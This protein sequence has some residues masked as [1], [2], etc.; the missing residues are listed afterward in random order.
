MAKLKETESHKVLAGDLNRDVLV[1]TP[2]GDSIGFRQGDVQVE[3]NTLLKL[4]EDPRVAHLAFD[5]GRS[6]YFGSII[7]GV[8]NSL[9]LKIRERG[10]RVALCD[11]SEDMRRMFRALA[12]ESVWTEYST[13]KAGLKALKD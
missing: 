1:V 10:G 4:C 13:L 7:I 12:L 5:L 8:L 3:M 6:A 11:V 9:A 2:L